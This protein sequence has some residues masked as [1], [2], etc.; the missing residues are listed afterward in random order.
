[1]VTAW[2]RRLSVTGAVRRSVRLQLL[3]TMVLVMDV[4]MLVLDFL[5][6]MFVFVPLRHVEPGA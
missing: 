6:A 3:V 2:L 5:V 1:M 4:H